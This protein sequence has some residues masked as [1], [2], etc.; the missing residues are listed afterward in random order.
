MPTMTDQQTTQ[1]A[2]ETAY[3]A[4]L[5]VESDAMLVD[6][7]TESSSSGSTSSSSDDSMGMQPTS[8]TFI[9]AMAD[10]YSRRYLKE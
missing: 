5:V 10:L 2:L 9:D 3:L 1:E 6:S 4:S 7:E 8:Q